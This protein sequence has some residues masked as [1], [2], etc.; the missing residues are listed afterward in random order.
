MVINFL[1]LFAKS[2][3]LF[4]TG[5]C[6]LSITPTHTIFSVVVEHNAGKTC[7]MF[8]LQH[9]NIFYNMQLMTFDMNVQREH[10]TRLNNLSQY[11]IGEY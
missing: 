1:Q 7:N 10:F 6:P 9:L 3:P 4:Q 11:G 8:T 2:Q 5:V